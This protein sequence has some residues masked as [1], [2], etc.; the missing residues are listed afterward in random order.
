MVEFDATWFYYWAN[1][2]Y[3]SKSFKL[4]PQG[5]WPMFFFSKVVNKIL[6][7]HHIWWRCK[8]K[9]QKKLYIYKSKEYIHLNGTPLCHWA[10]PLSASP[11]KASVKPPWI[12][13]KGQ[14][15]CPWRRGQ[16]LYQK[17]RWKWSYYIIYIYIYPKGSMGRVYLP[18]WM[19][20]LYGKDTI[21]GCYGYI[22]TIKIP[23]LI[24]LWLFHWPHFC[25]NCKNRIYVTITCPLKCQ[26]QNHVFI[27][28]T[29][30]CNKKLISLSLLII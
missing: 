24:T 28:F 14:H 9:V 25:C 26:S 3:A 19:V 13:S 1:W 11:W 4:L 12:R 5:I 20:D 8:H 10:Q 17:P 27:R 22:Q 30:A 16:I 29:C 2:Y 21:H 23:D 18:T 15:C 7:F 6:M